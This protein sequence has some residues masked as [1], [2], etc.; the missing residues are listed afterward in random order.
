MKPSPVVAEAI[1]VYIQYFGVLSFGVVVRMRK[2]VELVFVFCYGF[3]I[4]LN[5]QTS[6]M[7]TVFLRFDSNVIHEAKACS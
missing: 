2:N 6:P 1:E 7:V 3:G 4:F 5:R